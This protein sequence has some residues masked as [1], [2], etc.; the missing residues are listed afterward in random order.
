MFAIGKSPF[1]LEDWAGALKFYQKSRIYAP[2]DS[3][4][5]KGIIE[6]SWQKEILQS[7]PTVFYLVK[8]A[9][10]EQDVI[11]SYCRGL[12]LMPSCARQELAEQ[13]L[14]ACTEYD[15]NHPPTLLY[16]SGIAFQGKFKS[17]LGQLNQLWT[18]AGLSEH[19][20]QLIGVGRYLAGT[21]GEDDVVNEM[22]DW[23]SD[24]DIGLDDG[25]SEDGKQL[26][27]RLF[28]IESDVYLV[29]CQR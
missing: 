28:G 2:S 4:S 1:D 6:C 8:N 16:L 23:L 12:H 21:V 27:E 22:T 5:L 9:T 25:A 3:R 7:S 26:T 10:D 19:F 18:K 15:Q 20:I 24:K 11:L 13:R 14:L 29:E 17:M